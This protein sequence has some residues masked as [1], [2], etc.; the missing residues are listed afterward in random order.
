VD[1]QATARNLWLIMSGMIFA[2]REVLY[3]SKY[4]L[5]LKIPINSRS[6]YI[7]QGRISGRIIDGTFVHCLALEARALSINKDAPKRLCPASL[8]G[9]DSARS[10]D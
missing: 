1:Y 3:S 10:K 2:N 9:Q 5:L 7:T 8:P 4:S 6:R